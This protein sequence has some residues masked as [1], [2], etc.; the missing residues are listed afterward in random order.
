MN[1]RI[2]H[3]E[4]EDLLDSAQAKAENAS[5]LLEKLQRSRPDELSNKLVELS[6]KH[7][8]IRLNELRA[9]RLAKDLEEK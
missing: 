1:L 5:D 4:I 9:S 7:Q 8:Q 2:K 6:E 3:R